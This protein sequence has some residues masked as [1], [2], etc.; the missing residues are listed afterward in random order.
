MAR[1]FMGYNRFWRL[2]VSTKCLRKTAMNYLKTLSL[3]WLRSRSFSVR[4][5][6]L[7]CA[8]LPLVTACIWLQRNKAGTLSALC[9]LHN[10]HIF[11]AIPEQGLGREQVRFDSYVLCCCKLKMASAKS[12]SNTK[13]KTLLPYLK[14]QIFAPCFKAERK[15]LH[16]ERDKRHDGAYGPRL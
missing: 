15:P 9:A 1:P 11:P 4:R 3:S 6:E 14:K 10:H 13:F 7:G 16:Y 8:C 5:R 2:F 12:G